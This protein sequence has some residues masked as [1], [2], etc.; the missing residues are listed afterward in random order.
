MSEKRRNYTKEI[1]QLIDSLIKQAKKKG[2]IQG[3]TIKDKFSRYVSADS[4]IENIFS[5]FEAE[6]I[7]I[8]FSEDEDYFLDNEED[9]EID[10]PQ[11]TPH[12]SSLTDPLQIYLH[13]IHK[14]P[15]LSYKET[16]V[17]AKKINKGDLI[18][19]EHMINCNLKF[20]FMI[21]KKYTRTGLPLLDL[22]QQAN[23]GLMDAV[24]KYNPNRG[25]QFTSY[26]I[27]WV[28]HAILCYIKDNI[29]M[30]KTPACVFSDLSKISKAKQTFFSELYRY[31]TDSELAT[32]TGL[33][34]AR[35]R[36]LKE[37]DFEVVSTE[38]KPDETL[39]G[40]YEDIIPS[41]NDGDENKEIYQEDC[42]IQIQG[43]LL[44]L[45]ERERLVIELR[46]G[47]SDNGTMP[48]K[49]LS[50]VGTILGLSKERVRQI[51]ERALLRLRK[52][53]NISSL[54]DYLDI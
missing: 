2:Y 32:I 46:F 3:S 51:E 52:M 21:A 44:K 23:I 29:R 1:N 7:N 31:P 34:I 40:V 37:I 13:E 8:I 15:S 27:F 4:E 36:Y 20:A 38:D 11:S 41:S 5:A 22:I 28:K 12:S 47:L 45:P 48:P 49:S 39:P 17:L 54:Y 30:V 50:E 9:L 19:R 10:I 24:D 26:A 42:R 25:S 14:Y 53:P 43:F 35:I 16:M 18:A 33:T 6:G